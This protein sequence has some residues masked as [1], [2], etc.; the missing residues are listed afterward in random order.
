VLALPPP[1]RPV[2]DDGG[3]LTPREAQ[4]AALIRSGCTNRQIGRRLGISEKTAEVHVHHVMRKLGAAN[5]AEVAAWVA[6]RDRPA[7]E[8]SP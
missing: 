6:A 3:A 2:A 5:R 1:R 8:P 7:P 4:V